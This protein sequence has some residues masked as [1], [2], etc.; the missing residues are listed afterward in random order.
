[1]RPFLLRWLRRLL[2]TTPLLL[3]FLYWASRTEAPALAAGVTKEVRHLTLA[4]QKVSVTLYYPAQRDQAPLVV[5]AH[6]FTRAKRHM[7]GW[8]A[9]LAAQGF[10]VAVPTQPALLDHALNGRVLAELV[11]T[12][13]TT[14]RTALMGFSMGGLTTLLAAAQTPVDAWVGLDPVD[15]DGSGQKI[16]ASLKMPCAVLQAEPE[17]WNR[18]GNAS[19]IIAALPGETFVI[20]VRNATHLD[21]ESPTDLLGQLACGFVDAKRHALFKHYA[22]AFLKATLMNDEDAAKVLA[23]A[24]GD[25]ALTQ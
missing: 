11:V 21:A 5:V 17:A 12:F 20:R 16:A 14:H 19:G 7:A 10:I 18:Q 1:M 23:G 25:A 22:I 2:I 13:K 24:V 4:G 6:G 15:M 8:G 3:G 9:D